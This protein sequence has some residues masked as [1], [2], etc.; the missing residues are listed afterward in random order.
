[1]SPTSETATD[2]PKPSTA[3][4][5]TMADLVLDAAAKYNGGTAL[6]YPV[7]SVWGEISYPKLGP[8]VREIAKGLIALGVQP[9]DRVALLSN[10]RAEW[11]LADFGIIC[12]GAI[13]V[14]VYQT[15]SPDECLYVIEHSGSTAIFCEDDSQI[16][17]IDAIRDKLPALKHV[18][19]FEGES[20]GTLTLAQLK[21]R[22]AD[23]TDEQFDERA[24]AAT[25]D[26]VATIVYTS[27]T[28]GPPKGC[29]LTHDNLRADVDGTAELVVFEP[30]DE[31]VYIFLPLAHV[32]YAARPDAR[33]R[34][35]RHARLLASR[36]EEDRGRRRRDRA[37][38]AAVGAAGVREDLHGGDEPGRGRGRPEGQALLVGRRRRAQGA[39]ARAQ[40]RPQRPAAERAVRARREARPAQ[41]PRAVRRPDQA[42]DDRRCADRRRHP[43]VLPRDGRVGARGLRDDRDVGRGDAEHDLRASPRHRRQGDPRLRAARS[44]RTA[45]SSCAG[46]TSSRATTTTRPRRRRTLR[47]RLAALGR[48]RR[49][50]RRRLP[51]D[52]RPQEGPHHHV[53]R[54]E[55]VAVEHRERAEGQP[56]GVAGGRLRRPQAVPRPRS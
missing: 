7:G 34:P 6:K 19:R 31:V 45:R 26:D 12:A 54:Q 21:E 51:H 1:M 2:A 43:L 55:R 52:H 38:P 16:A 56:L 30:K 47:R 53:E 24:H 3:K 28:T 15:N 11:T 36:P 42:R 20:E 14:P 17:K 50:R 49:D 25:A 9:G 35:G 27:G 5:R 48:P 10:T 32:L 13:V 23:I 4:A 40:G 37:D 22:G 29:M 41:G 46:R 8:G 44:P 33:H 39:R 18:I